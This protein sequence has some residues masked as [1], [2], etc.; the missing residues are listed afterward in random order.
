MR[1]DAGYRID[2][3]VDRNVVIE[4]KSVER[5]E[6]IHQA[7]LLAYLRLSKLNLG[8]LINFNCR[9]LKDGLHRRVLDLPPNPL[10]PL[11]PLR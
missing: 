5:I 9:L 7:Q 2:L 1:I 10:R 11:R 3:L 6:P 4:L 8:Y